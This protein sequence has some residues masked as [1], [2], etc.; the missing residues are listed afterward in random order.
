M[1]AKSCKD[2]LEAHKHEASVHAI[3]LKK[4]K[5]KFVAVNIQPATVVQQCV[6]LFVFSQM[7]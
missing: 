4:G 7:F 3:K 5:R 6:Y 1:S 2:L